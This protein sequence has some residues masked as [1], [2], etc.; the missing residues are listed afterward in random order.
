MLG[1]QSL[2]KFMFIILGTLAITLIIWAMVMTPPNA[3]NDWN[4][5]AMNDNATSRQFAGDVATQ[6]QAVGD[7]HSMFVQDVM[8]WAAQRYFESEWVF[9]T[10]E[11]GQISRDLTDD[12]WDSAVAK[13]PAGEFTP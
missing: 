13:N 9:M 12:A 1:F 2:S 8:W 10:G 3:L 7:I 6:N 5:Q 4:I 11:N